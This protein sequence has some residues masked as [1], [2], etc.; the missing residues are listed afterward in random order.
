MKK[1]C[2]IEKKLQVRGCQRYVSRTA[3]AWY[4]SN[5]RGETCAESIFSSLLRLYSGAS[6]I[7]KIAHENGVSRLIHVSH[8][9]AKAD[10]ESAFYRTKYE[11][12]VAVREAFAG[13]TIA[14]PGP[15]F[16]G[17]DW[18]LNAVACESGCA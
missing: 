12:E 18:L 2:L 8:L 13:A 7:A 5:S 15:L 14:R 11:G 17:E 1:R 16:G 9:N 6:Q 3:P 4:G 10:S